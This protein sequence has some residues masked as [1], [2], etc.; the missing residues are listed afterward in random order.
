MATRTYTCSVCD[1]PF[2]V[3]QHGRPPKT[4]SPE[5][6]AEAIRR[7]HADRHEALYEPHPRPDPRGC[8]VIGCPKPVHTLGYCAAHAALFK[9]YG[10]ADLPEIVCMDCG[11]GT[12]KNGRR[13]MRC[14][15]CS[16][17]H[18]AVTMA[19]R[20]RSR[21]AKNPKGNREQRRKDRLAQYGLTAEAFDAM[22]ERQSGRC[23]ICSTDLDPDST[24]MHIDHCHAS[25][26]VRGLLCRSCNL[27]LGCFKDDPV[28]L[29]RAVA[30][31]MP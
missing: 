19:A 5:C 29:T 13:R 25:S 16:D 14:R 22:F 10:T 4:C 6:R 12:G 17:V 11:K 9:K 24:D 30:Y 15:S 31:L 20:Q 18:R 21:R 2:E 7:Y 1:S 3:T 8:L 26:V 27:G 28:R 23:A